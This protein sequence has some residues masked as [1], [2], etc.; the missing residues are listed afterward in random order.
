MMRHWTLPQAL[1]GVHN[2]SQGVISSK[3]RDGLFFKT[4]VHL[5]PWLKLEDPP[6]NCINN[7]KNLSSIWKTHLSTQILL[8]FLMTMMCLEWIFECFFQ[9]EK[10]M[11]IVRF[12]PV[13]VMLLQVGRFCNS[14]ILFF[15][16]EGL[17]VSKLCIRYI[18]QYVFATVCTPQKHD[19]PHIFFFFFIH[20]RN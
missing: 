20:S 12:M 17:N 10:I 16:T 4:Q 6:F 7:M 14:F 19:N 3:I 18:Y 15:Y 9:K 1:T 8:W 5:L 11:I 2:L 13:K